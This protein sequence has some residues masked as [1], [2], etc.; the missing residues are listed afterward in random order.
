MENC[1]LLAAK[2]LSSL[3]YFISVA[4]LSEVNCALSTIHFKG[5]AFAFTR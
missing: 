4:T 1:M 2:V 3:I 5:K